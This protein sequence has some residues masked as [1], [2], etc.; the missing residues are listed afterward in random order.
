LT[1]LVVLGWAAWSFLF[2][3]P[4]DSDQTAVPEKPFAVP[5]SKDGVR[6]DLDR[7]E[8]GSFTMGGIPRGLGTTP[9]FVS[10]LADTFPATLVH[11]THGFWLG[12]FDVTVGQWHALM[13]KPLYQ[14]DPNRVGDQGPMTGISWLGAMDFCQRMNAQ[15][16]AAGRLPAG[17]EYRLPT[18]AEWEYACRAGTN[19]GEGYDGHEVT[20][21]MGWFTSNSGGKVHPVGLKEPNAWGLFDMHGN[22]QQWC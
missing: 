4:A 10:Q 11:L 6:V 17:Y 19:N 12:K 2:D 22:V 15:E 8:P 18:E 16:R 9:G 13:G 20:D 1:V 7:I 3:V 5:P 14:D 21:A